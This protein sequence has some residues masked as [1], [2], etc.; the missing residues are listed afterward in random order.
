MTNVKESI[1]VDNEQTLALYIVRTWVPEE[2]LEEWNKWHTEV[3]VPEVATQPGVLWARKYRVAEDNH[4]GDWTPQYVT[5]YEFESLAAFEAYR[6]GETAA[7]LRKE[8]DD[9]YG[10]IGKISRQVIVQIATIEDI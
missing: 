4:L 3:H 7:R 9:R 10:P 1:N 2:Q 8:Y 5:I 6:N